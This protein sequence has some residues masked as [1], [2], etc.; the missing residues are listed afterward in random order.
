MYDSS[1]ACP[2]CGNDKRTIE[3]I[4]ESINDLEIKNLSE[5]KIDEFD[6]SSFVI[7]VTS[8]LKLPNIQSNPLKSAKLQKMKNMLDEYNE[9]FEDY[10]SAE[11]EDVESFVDRLIEIQKEINVELPELLDE[12]SE[13]L[14]G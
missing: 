9:L 12:L 2:H 10:E 1:H 5:H 6:S 3:E 11:N 8:A 14:F 4:I 13:S 7:A